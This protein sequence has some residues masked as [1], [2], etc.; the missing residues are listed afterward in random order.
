[1][2]LYNPE[3]IEEPPATP[4]DTYIYGQKAQSLGFAKKGLF[5]GFG[6]CLI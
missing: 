4:I 6:R 3:T 5:K 2:G 1:M